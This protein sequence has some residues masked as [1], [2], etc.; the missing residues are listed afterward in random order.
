MDTNI[1]AYKQEKMR[2]DQTVKGTVGNWD[3]A[4]TLVDNPERKKTRTVYVVEFDKDPQPLPDSDTMDVG[5]FK[6]PSSE[7][8]SAAS[9]A[10]MPASSADETMTAPKFHFP[11]FDAGQN[12][13]TQAAPGADGVSSYADYVVKKDDTLQKIAKKFY[14]NYSQWTKI[15]DV[16]KDVIKNPNFIK[17]GITI[18]IPMK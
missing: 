8:K 3:N 7:E 9:E 17:P 18:K 13:K 10:S 2:V 5:Q 15:Y 1:R 6:Q 12:T 16:N 14:G 4:P 11:N